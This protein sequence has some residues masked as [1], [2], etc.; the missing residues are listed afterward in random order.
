MATAKPFTVVR[1]EPLHLDAAAP[2]CDMYTLSPFVWKSNSA[3]DLLV[4]AV[5]HSDTASEK[6]ARIYHG[7]STDG[8]NFAMDAEPVIPPGPSDLDCDG[9]EDPTVA[10]CEGVY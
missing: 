4:R 5:N 3:H 10:S 1:M 2:L 7:V 8:L 6:V 9:C